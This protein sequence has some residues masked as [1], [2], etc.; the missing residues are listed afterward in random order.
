MKRLL[1]LLSCASLI[2]LVISCGKENEG[3][4]GTEFDSS[5]IPGKW[6]QGQYYEKYLSD[7]TGS[8]WDESVDQKE[9]E[10]QKFTWSLS[11]DELT[12]VHGM[13][14]GQTKIPKVYTV[15]ELTNSTFKYKDNY[16][17]SY[18]FIRVN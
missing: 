8:T 14:I 9:S 17:K 7:G 10:A 1:C 15:T 16:G 12:Q 13:E 5:L 18:S 11:K 3:T 4:K 6:Q 2:L